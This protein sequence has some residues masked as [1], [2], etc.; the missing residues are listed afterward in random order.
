MLS[1]QV[2]TAYVI[3]EYIMAS[4]YASFSWYDYDSEKSGTSI[5]LAETTELTL[6]AQNI[7]IEA[8]R[9]AM[10]GLTIAP[11]SKSSQ[12]DIIFDTPVVPTDPFAQREIKWVVIAQD[13]AGNKFKANEIPTANLDLLEGGSKYIVKSGVVTVVAAAAAVA[14]FVTAYE[15]L[16]LSQS[17]LA[18]TVVDIY[19]VGR[20]N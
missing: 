8:L 15:A 20:N 11:V 12:T 17:G 13:S 3:G 6:A 19:Q 18:L 7:A 9:T 10:N 16:A 1:L 4:D 5:N 2:K 14:A